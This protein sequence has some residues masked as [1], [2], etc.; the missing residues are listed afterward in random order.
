MPGGT[1]HTGLAL[2]RRREPLQQIERRAGRHLR[3]AGQLNVASRRADV[4][5]TEP[6][7]NGV[8]VDAGFEEVRRERVAQPVN[9]SGLRDPRPE[10][11]GLI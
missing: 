3:V 5:V 2:R 7:L 9:A 4:A 1:A 6:P 10:L 8:K 11:G